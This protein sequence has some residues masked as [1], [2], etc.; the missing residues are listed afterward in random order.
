MMQAAEVANLDD[1][2]AIQGMDIPA[3]WA[4]HLQGLMNSPFMVVAEVAGEYA[5]QVPFVHHDHVVE[6]FSTD[7]PDQP[8]HI[9]ILPGT[10]RCGDHLL[11][12]HVSDAPLEVLTIDSVMIS[13]EVSRGLVPRERLHDLLGRPLCRR[14][15]GDVEMENPASLV[16]E[17]QE[18][19][20]DSIA[21]GG[22][23]E[24]VDGGD[25]FDV[26]PQ[27]SSPSGGGRSLPSDHVFLDRRFVQI[28]SDLAQ[29]PD[30]VR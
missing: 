17:D 25:V 11:D 23:N 16:G 30:N 1:T 14:I 19:K 28:D 9:R 2:A 3:L 29:L 26:I 6:A 10:S 15:R 8:F 5:T 21:N 22:H 24:E 12:A 18:D 13:E 27:E 4:I 7:A 20:E